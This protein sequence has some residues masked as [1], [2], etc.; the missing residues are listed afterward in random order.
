MHNMFYNDMLLQSLDLSSWN[1]KLQLA[2][3]AK[4]DLN[5]G[6]GGMFANTVSLKSLN[7]RNLDNT[8]DSAQENMFT[9]NASLADSAT[10]PLSA[11][12]FTA[13]LT[14]LTTGPQFIMNREN[15]LN[16][17]VPDTV[18]N[19]YDSNGNLTIFVGNAINT[20][21]ANPGNW[22]A[23]QAYRLVDQV[24]GQQIGANHIIQGLPG[25]QVTV[26]IPNSYRLVNTNLYYTDQPVQHTK[27]AQFTLAKNLDI[28]KPVILYLIKEV[29]VTV[30][31]VDHNQTIATYQKTVDEETDMD[32]S[33]QL[34]KGYQAA[35]KTDLAFQVGDQDLVVNIPVLTGAEIAP[36]STTPTSSSATQSN[37]TSTSKSATTS[38]AASTSSSATKSNT[39][40]TSESA[41]TSSVA[42]T[43]SSATQSNTTST[44]ESATTSSAASTSSSAT[45]SNTTSTSGSATKSNTASTSSSST[46]SS[47]A[48]T[49]S[50][51]T[52]SNTASTSESA[53]TSS[54]ASTSS[55]A[56]KSNT[57]STSGSATKSNT[58]STSSSS[59]KSNTASTSSSVTKS[60]TTSTS[61]S[62][63]TPIN[64]STSN[65]ATKSSES[66]M[67]STSSLTE[68][69]STQSSSAT[70]RRTA[71]FQSVLP[72]TGKQR[73]FRLAFLN[74]LTL[75]GSS[76]AAMKIFGRKH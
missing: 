31:F 54:V 38:S 14:D 42:S 66:A 68:S 70:E 5:D 61:E 37:T 62:A 27:I 34:P 3:G 48:S 19:R 74:L 76:F 44:S 55:S 28:N 15:D 64:T 32:V 45:K 9:M 40:S 65:S 17:T 12:Q 73:T 10:S 47:T 11:K 22:Q 53:T 13:H 29:P 26:T 56:T 1:A 4:K 35:D 52:K 20:G 33:S 72:A 24:T 8:A 46:Q 50:S 69:L 23:G 7:I 58:A 21:M 63:T 67:V 71:R 6:T 2:P 25:S 39:A 49:S 59:T 18:W 41:T 60:N 75:I 30:N 43:S 57:T 51:S 16:T 36:T